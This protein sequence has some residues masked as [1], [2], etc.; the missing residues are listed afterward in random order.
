MHAVLTMNSINNSLV[1]DG[2]AYDAF[3]VIHN[4]DFNAG[5]SVLMTYALNGVRQAL[6][7]NWLPVINFDNSCNTFFYDPERGENIWEY[8]WEPVMGVS[9]D[10]LLLKKAN[11][12]IGSDQIKRFKD[13]QIFDWHNS[14]PDRIATFWLHEEPGDPIEWMRKHRE[15]GRYYVANFINVRPEIISKADAFA[16]E[17][18]DGSFLFTVHIRGTD[19]SYA[20]PTN[21][22]RYFDRIR[23]IIADRNLDKFQVFLATDQTQFVDI[24]QKEFADRLV[25]YDSARGESFIAPFKLRDVPPYKKGEDVLIDILLLAKGNHLLKCAASVGEY[26]A[27]FNPD[28]EITDFGVESKFIKKNHFLISTG[29]EKL[30]LLESPLQEFFVAISR[31]L[32]NYLES[33]V[34]KFDQRAW[35]HPRIA[36]AYGLR[37]LFSYLPRLLVKR[38]LKLLRVLLIKF[39]SRILRVCFQVKH[40]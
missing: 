12:D 1:Y 11:G 38:F 31:R 34:F 4:P 16:R 32:T 29:F 15:I 6:A 40:D 33:V 7:R 25:S 30:G 26:G 37:Y 18:F 22:Q 21:H 17:R 23:Q 9:Y 28:I 3:V 36:L 19:W 35:A 5:F 14:D 8:F 13:Q 24:F 20:E 2:H 27:W 39:P 10:D